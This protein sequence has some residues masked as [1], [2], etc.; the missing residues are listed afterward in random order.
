MN[1]A[2]PI[3]LILLLAAVGV[4]LIRRQPTSTPGPT[5]IPT[6]EVVEQLPPGQQPKVSLKFT[7]DG[8]YVTV[9]ISNIQAAQI[10]Y[11]LIYDATVKKT[12][13][14]TGV[15]GGAK[16][17]GKTEYSYKQL[18]GSESSGKFTYHENIKNAVMELTLRND[19]NYSVFSATYPFTLTPGKSVELKAQE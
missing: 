2:I 11:N 13:I 9:D 10:E 16:L 8:H 14:N 4:F 1:K 7:A 3:V 18:L 6:P 5:P 15:T 19:S 17:N 12:Q